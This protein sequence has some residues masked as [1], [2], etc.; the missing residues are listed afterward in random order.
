[1]QFFLWAIAA[2][3]AIPFLL[4]VAVGFGNWRRRTQLRGKRRGF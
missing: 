1:M 3:M 2:S 4:L